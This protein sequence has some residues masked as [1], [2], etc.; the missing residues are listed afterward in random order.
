MAAEID[1]E[2]L[3]DWDILG[4][5]FVMV[6]GGNDTTGN[7]ISH[8]VMLLDADHQARDALVSRPRN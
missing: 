1:G 3:T 6:A 2:R 7:L 8:G 5:C 4:F